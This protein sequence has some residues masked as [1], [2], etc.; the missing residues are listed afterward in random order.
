MSLLKLYQEWAEAREAWDA[1]PMGPAALRFREA[2]K[3][4]VDTMEYGKCYRVTDGVAIRLAAGD[5]IDVMLFE[6][7]REV[8]A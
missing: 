2:R 5:V 3:A 1:C 6:D 4:L 7:C 8:P